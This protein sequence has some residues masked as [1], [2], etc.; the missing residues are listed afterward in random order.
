[1]KRISFIRACVAATVIIAAAVAPASY[2][3]A[4]NVGG[5]MLLASFPSTMAPTPIVA[6]EPIAVDRT[7]FIGPPRV[8]VGGWCWLVA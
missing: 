4:S 8:R 5:G 7:P 3:H 2:A 1:M 6:A